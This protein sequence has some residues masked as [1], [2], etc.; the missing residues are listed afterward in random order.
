MAPKTGE[1][2]A[3]D[4]DSQAECDCER[5]RE[6]K[7]KKGRCA[8]CGHR[9]WHHEIDESSSEVED[10]ST[11]KAAPTNVLDIVLGAIPKASKASGKSKNGGQIISSLFGQ[12]NKEAN[13]GM[14]PPTS[15]A[16]SS[17]KKDKG[18]AKSDGKTKSAE[19]QDSNLFKAL[20]IV[21]IPDGVVF[22]V[23]EGRH[24][25]HTKTPDR[26]TVGTLARRGLAAIN[27]NGFD[28]DRTW[29]HE[30]LAD[31]LFS[32]LPNVFGWFKDLEA[33]T[34]GA[35][36]WF[37]G[38]AH[39]TKLQ[40]VAS[41]R[42]TGFDVEYNSVQSRTSFRNVQIIILARQAIPIE[43]SS[44]WIDQEFLSF[45]AQEEGN[46][47]PSRSPSPEAGPS[48]PRGRNKRLVS[49]SS[50]E[51]G[52]SA[53]QKPKPSKKARTRRWTRSKDSDN[54]AGECIDLTADE[55]P[56]LRPATPPIAP[57]FPE[58]VSPEQPININPYDSTRS[59]F[60]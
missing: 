57:P 21:V 41:L 24:I 6:K 49:V 9:R 30:Q 60:F 8:E 13:K 25:V 32:V 23:Q 27:Q 26:D 15:D 3:Q 39:R 54:S 47:P 22:S 12:A 35:P 37:L 19:A 38:S 17:T 16:G 59:F 14:R 42:P 52:G 28:L 53:L 20:A 2:H 4:E 48:V 31:F 7:D 55:A 34:P 56:V 18:K 45:I 43:T 29:T 10:S 51:E 33:E 46:A 58:P 40:V 5:Y 1:C 36:Q 44:A 11:A 50:D